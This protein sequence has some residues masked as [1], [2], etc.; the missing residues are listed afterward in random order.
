[1][2]TK[3]VPLA[4]L[5][6]DYQLYPRHQIDE[7][8][9]NDMVHAL[10]AGT[11]LPRIIAEEKTLRI[12]DGF[13]RVRAFRKVLGE[14]GSVRVELRGYPDEIELFADAARLNAGHGRKLNRN[15]QIRIILRGRDLGADDDT[16]ATWL[17]VGPERV[18]VLAVRV[19]T[20]PDGEQVALKRGA[21]H[22]AGRH[23]TAEQV[24]AL[25]QMRGAQTLRL[26]RE[27]IRLLETDVANLADDGVRAELL[28][29]ADLVHSKVTPEAV[30]S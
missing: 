8:H 6:E 5:V 15:D 17:H 1:M 7:V 26:V 27:L 22:F 12:V 19:A 23:M 2:K 10:Q 13:H 14:D 29:L 18:H 21:E 3:L 25:R 20:G 9:V 16:I 11:P 30:A 28:R 24:G 4:S